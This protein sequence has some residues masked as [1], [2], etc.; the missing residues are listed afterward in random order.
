MTSVA[1]DRRRG[2]ARVQYNTEA[3]LTLPDRNRVVFGRTANLSPSGLYVLSPMVYGV[4]TQISCTF[5][6]QRQKLTLRGRVARVI[7]AQPSGMG[8]AFTNLAE[9]D[10]YCDHRSAI[11]WRITGLLSR[12]S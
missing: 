7:E 5:I 9:S 8:I 11:S 2:G 3:L 12:A 6:V 4:G 1:I 10:R